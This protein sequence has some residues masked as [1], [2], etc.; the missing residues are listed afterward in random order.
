MDIFDGV[1][2]NIF[3][4]LLSVS[5]FLRRKGENAP[6][7]N[8][9]ETQSMKIQVKSGEMQFARKLEKLCNRRTPKSANLICYPILKIQS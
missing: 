4:R 5:F 7:K 6:V 1:W 2:R 3:C 8:P 9:A